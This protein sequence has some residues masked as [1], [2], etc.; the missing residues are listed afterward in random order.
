MSNVMLDADGFQVAC[1][2]IPLPWTPDDDLP[3][4]SDFDF[5]PDWDAAFDRP[6]PEDR[7][8]WARECDER[9]RLE[10][11]SPFEPTDADW[12]E[13]ARWCEWVDMKDRERLF[14]DEDAQAAGLAIG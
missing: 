10:L 3:P 11:N 2:D 1:W 4:S 12:D 14:T 6:F 8:W 7:E 13:M 9:E 5:E